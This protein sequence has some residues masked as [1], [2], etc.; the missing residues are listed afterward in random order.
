MIKDTAASRVAN[1]GPNPKPGSALHVSP[2]A[3]GH[4]GMAG[5]SI[6][7]LSSLDVP[8]KSPPLLTEA[9]VRVLPGWWLL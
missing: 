5:K 1:M 6:T 9:V 4:V 8:S 2:Q 3:L 7:I